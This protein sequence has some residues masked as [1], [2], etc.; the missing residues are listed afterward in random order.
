MINQ[1]QLTFLFLDLGNNLFISIG[2]YLH[3]NDEYQMTVHAYTQ[4]IQ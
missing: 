1:M 4:Y 2:V 3:R